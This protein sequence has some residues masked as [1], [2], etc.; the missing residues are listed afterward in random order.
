MTFSYIEKLKLY[1]LIIMAISEHKKNIDEV[2]DEYYYNVKESL[3]GLKE[4]FRINFLEKNLYYK[5]GIDNIQA[6]H[7]Y[8]I[9]LLNHK[10]TPRKVRIKLREINSDELEAQEP[11][12][13]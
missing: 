10:Y 13:E 9:E 7:K 12:L 8:V 2:F 1:G 5:C 3:D 4:I 11:F 6:I